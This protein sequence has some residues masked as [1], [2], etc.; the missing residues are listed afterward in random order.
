[1]KKLLH[2]SFIKDLIKL[3][4]LNY[5]KIKE[6]KVRLF[7]FFMVFTC[8]LIW[9]EAGSVLHAQAPQK[10][11]Y[12]AVIRNASHDLVANTAIGIRVSILQGSAGNSSEEFSQSV[13][14]YIETH[15]ATTNFNGLVTIQIGDGSVYLGNF[16]NI[17]WGAGPYFIKTEI[18]ITGGTAYSI[19]G[20]HQL[21]SVPY[22]LYA[23][24]SGNGS[25]SGQGSTGS[26]GAVGPTGNNGEKGIAGNTGSTGAAGL[27]GGT[28]IIGGTGVRGVTGATG[29][30]GISG[31]VGPTGVKGSTGLDGSNGFTGQTGQ[32]GTTGSTGNNGNTGG[33]GLNGFTGHTG[34]NGTTGNN[35]N[36]GA[37]GSNGF[38]GHTGQNGTTGST[39]NN[40]NTGATGSNGFTGQ[41][42]TTGS[43]GNNG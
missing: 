30:A 36:T 15:T 32:N 14:V 20:I 38:T 22:A 25:G 42:G 1:M 7:L 5:F 37:T 11:S 33:T 23:E 34:Q 10:M 29:A 27:P 13:I 17:N 24:R 4:N 21:M 18:D 2:H 40:G 35:G 19:N 41:N 8:P 12:Q 3:S 39:G 16:S 31:G 43:T 6:T 26:T 28:G 9:K